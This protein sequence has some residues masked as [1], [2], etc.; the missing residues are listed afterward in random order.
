MLVQDFCANLLSL[1]SEQEL[2]PCF[3]YFWKGKSYAPNGFSALAWALP[4]Q[5]KA[6]PS[7]RLREQPNQKT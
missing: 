7:A 5:L 4:H 2:F 6:A 1:R 3:L